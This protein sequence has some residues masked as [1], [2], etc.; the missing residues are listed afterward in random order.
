MLCLESVQKVVFFFF[1]SLC[2]KNIVSCVTRI[3][4]YY[5]KQRLKDLFHFVWT[6]QTF[7]YAKNSKAEVDTYG[8]QMEDLKSSSVG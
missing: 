6:I 5:S 8:L 3:S 7:H 1:N 2:D 4:Q